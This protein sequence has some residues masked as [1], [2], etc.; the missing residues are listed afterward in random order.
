MSDDLD[1]LVRRAAFDFLTKQVALRGP[2]LSRRVLE[3]GFPLEGQ[4]VSLLGPPGIFKPALLADMPLSI[5]TVPEIEGKER[6]YE[7][8]VDEQGRLLYRYRGTDPKHPDNVGLRRAMER[9]APLVYFYGVIPGLYR[10]IWPVFVVGDDPAG[11]TFTVEERPLLEVGEA[12]ARVGE[13]A[14]A[15]AVRLVPQ[16]LHQVAFRRRVIWAYRE[17][18]SVCRLRHQELLDAAHILPDTH[19]EGRP[20]V[21]NGLALCKLHH[22]AFDTNILGVR[23]DLVIE[24]RRDVLDEIDGPMLVHG[25]QGFQEAKLHAPRTRGLYPNPDFL[26]ERYEIFRAAG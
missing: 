10:P 25:L 19:P 5:T 9:Q 16:R 11:L 2:E 17:N 3:I 15:Y 1:A 14:R 23:P 24:I 20:I 8:E 22:A 4:D 21:P 7:D 6:P 12:V 26:A 18:C 13:D